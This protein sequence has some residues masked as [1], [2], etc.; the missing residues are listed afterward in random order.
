M[1]HNR[2]A[3]TAIC[4]KGHECRHSA[5]GGD[6]TVQLMATGHTAGAQA[7]CVAIRSTVAT[8]EHRC[9]VTTDLPVPR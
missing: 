5:A 9:D 3:H 4:A 2:A 8:A 7:L 1:R 6:G